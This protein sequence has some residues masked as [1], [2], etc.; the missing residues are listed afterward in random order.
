MLLSLTPKRTK[1]YA[2]D[3][4]RPVEKKKLFLNNRDKDA[5]NILKEEMLSNN[6]YRVISFYGARHTRG[7]YDGIIE[8]NKK[9]NFNCS[10]ITIKSNII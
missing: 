8:L 5:V 6:I 7:I 3:D 4:N 10:I 1:I 2:T 9:Q